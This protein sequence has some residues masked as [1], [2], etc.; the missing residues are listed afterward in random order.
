MSRGLWSTAAANERR[1]FGSTREPAGRYGAIR[2]DS[3][4]GEKARITSNVTV[5]NNFDIRAFWLLFAVVKYIQKLT[6][7]LFNA[8]LAYRSQAGL[9][10]SETQ[11]FISKSTSLAFE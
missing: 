3:T 4:E 6:G 5:A 1:G 11:I 10:I 7:L 9:I 2:E 8:Y